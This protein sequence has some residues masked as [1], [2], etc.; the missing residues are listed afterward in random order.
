MTR[1]VNPML[2]KIEARNNRKLRAAIN[3]Q[4]EGW[5]NG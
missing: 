2:A 3:A 5:S 4:I 1:R